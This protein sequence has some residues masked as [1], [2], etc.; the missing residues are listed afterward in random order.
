[1]LQK[2]IVV[3][4]LCCVFIPGCL[5]NQNS[6]KGSIEVN[7]SPHGA[8]VYIDNEFQGNTPI[9]IHN[10]TFGSSTVEL[11]YQGYQNWSKTVSI[12][13]TTVKLFIP[14]I[15]ISTPMTKPTP[16]NDKYE[17]CIE[18]FPGSHYYP[19]TNQCLFP[20]ETPT[21]FYK[22]CVEK[23]PGSHYYP[24]TNQC[25]YPSETPKPTQTLTISPTLDIYEYCTVNFPGSQYNSSTKQCEYPQTTIVTT[26][27]SN[28]IGKV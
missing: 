25:L 20:S 4:L 14:L 13:P 21:D 22:Y 10:I 18:H 11:R 6:E 15:P 7:S 27:R 17:Y 19:Q 5:F 23:F 3:I 1:M 9:A 26:Q 12:S 2:K 16:I 24:Q 8:A 28:I